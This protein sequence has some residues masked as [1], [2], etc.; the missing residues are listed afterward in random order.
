MENDAITVN[1]LSTI[2]E[3]DTFVRALFMD[4]FAAASE[5]IESHVDEKIAAIKQ[6]AS[7]R[8]H[9]LIRH[10]ALISGLLSSVVWL[11]VKE[12]RNKYE[13]IL[14][15]IPEL[16][17]LFSPQVF[18]EPDHVKA[19]LQHFFYFFE[20]ADRSSFSWS[21]LAIGIMQVCEQFLRIKGKD[22]RPYLVLHQEVVEIIAGFA[23]H[24]PSSR[25]VVEAI[26]AAS[27]HFYHSRQTCFTNLFEE[28]H[29]TTLCEIFY[30]AFFL[31]TYAMTTALLS[32]FS[33]P[34]SWSERTKMFEELLKVASNKPEGL[35]PFLPFIQDAFYNEP[36]NARKLAYECAVH[37]IETVPTMLEYFKASLIVALLHEK[38]H[39]SRTALSFMPQIITASMNEET[40]TALLDAAQIAV[41]RSPTP[42]ACTTF[43]LSVSASSDR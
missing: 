35:A 30:V 25:V 33:K 32:R 23:V 12:L 8:P 10:L 38:I 17:L 19:L 39:I 18:D 5:N 15:L 1:T 11:S 7:S 3:L 16:I 41:N 37:M 13:K 24:H 42:Q 34:S 43:A 14:N 2:K 28:S 6:F 31:T 9:V 36:S 21:N 4:L 40:T 29:L 26:A 22:A 27:D 20:K